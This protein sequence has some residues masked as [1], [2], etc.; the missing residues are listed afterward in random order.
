MIEDTKKDV[1]N[2]NQ[3][4]NIAT[5]TDAVN[6][7]YDD[8][9]FIAKLQEKDAEIRQL[10]QQI[11]ELSTRLKEVESIALE[12]ENIVAELAEI[13]AAK[14]AEDSWRIEALRTYIQ[15][16][17]PPTPRTTN[18]SIMHLEMTKE[19]TKKMEDHAGLPSR[20][21]SSRHNQ[22]ENQSFNSKKIHKQPRL[23][24]K[25]D[26]P[27]INLRDVNLSSKVTTA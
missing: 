19:S 13:I 9:T 14:E 26:I 24:Q 22:M 7:K 27:R 17:L 18:G 6:S 2:R 23:Q 10:Q 1:D 11:G 16:Q 8:A 4:E 20:N 15:Q 21:E 12:K 3:R 5:D 25:V